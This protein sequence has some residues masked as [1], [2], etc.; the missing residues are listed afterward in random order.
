[1]TKWLIFG[2][3]G[4]AGAA[5]F[6]GIAV[7]A[8]NAFDEPLRPE[9]VKIL[10]NE[11]QFSEAQKRAYFYILGLAKG[12][13]ENPEKKGEELWPHH[14]DPG[15]WDGIVRGNALWK[16]EFSGCAHNEACGVKDLEDD[17]KLLET[18]STNSKMLQH[19]SRLME[20]G[21][22]STLFRGDEKTIFA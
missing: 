17:P 20:Y 1:M 22:G 15:F 4:L 2:L 12:E 21:A 10:A 13:T 11:P 9:V 5:L 3:G 6:S 14:G 19:Y 16:A 8:I 18:L 7:S